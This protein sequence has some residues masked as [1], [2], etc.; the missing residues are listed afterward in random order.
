LPELLAVVE[1]RK[2]AGLEPLAGDGH[3]RHHAQGERRLVQGGPRLA[4][5]LALQRAGVA[6]HPEDHPR[7]QAGRRKADDG[8][9]P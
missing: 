2:S 1:I 5:Q 7:E 4:L 9:D 3:E 6:A 8:E